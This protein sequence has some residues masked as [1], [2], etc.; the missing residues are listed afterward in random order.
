MLSFANEIIE[1]E[2]LGGGVYERQ[3]EVFPLG[4]KY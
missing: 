4:I 2:K 3:K 1:I